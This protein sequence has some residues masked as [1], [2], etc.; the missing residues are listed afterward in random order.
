MMCIKDTQRVDCNP[1]FGARGEGP[2]GVCLKVAG[3]DV[4][5]VHNEEAGQKASTLFE[6]TGRKIPKGFR[7]QGFQT[8]DMDERQ[9]RRFSKDEMKT[10]IGLGL[11][12]DQHFQAT[13]IEP[14]DTPIEPYD[15]II[16]LGDDTTPYHVFFNLQPT[17]SLG[18]F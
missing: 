16:C 15:V 13:W 17:V 11:R 2:E 4:H 3:E 5:W 7:F 6:A 10:A 12:A 18:P 9:V 1:V 8:S 14:R